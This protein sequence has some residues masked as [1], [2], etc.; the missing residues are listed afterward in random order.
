MPSPEGA[1]QSSPKEQVEARHELR[2]GFISVRSR[3][4]EVT[5]FVPVRPWRPARP[6]SVHTTLPSSTQ[7]VPPRRHRAVRQLCHHRPGGAA[8]R[9]AGDDAG[10]DDPA[11]PSS[12]HASLGARP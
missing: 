10:G 8:R 6:A 12:P 3:L 7:A 4:R 11:P 2:R 1:R 9:V 5:P